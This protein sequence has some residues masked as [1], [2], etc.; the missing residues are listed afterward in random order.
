MSLVG[1]GS[2]SSVTVASSD[3]EGNRAFYSNF[4]AKIDVSAPGG[5]VRNETDTSVAV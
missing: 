5:E 2:P 1:E 3:R 4:G